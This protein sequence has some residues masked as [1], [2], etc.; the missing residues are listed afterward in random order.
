MK[1]K[2]EAQ[3]NRSRGGQPARRN[4]NFQRCVVR[5]ADR[6]RVRKMANLALLIAGGAVVPVP[7]GFEGESQH[8]RHKENREQALCCFARHTRPKHPKQ[9]GT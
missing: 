2:L 6:Y 9:H 8:C 1:Y 7:G 5:Q 4:R 3:I